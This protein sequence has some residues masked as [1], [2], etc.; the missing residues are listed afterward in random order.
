MVTGTR[1][2]ASWAQQRGGEGEFEIRNGS[3]LELSE[4]WNGPFDGF[5]FDPPYGRNAWKSTDGFDLLEG[6]L[7]AC[8]SV[9]TENANLVTLLPWPPSAIFE[10]IESGTSFGKSWAEISDA[11]ATAG[12]EIMSTTPI[13]VH[14]S[15]ARMLIHARKIEK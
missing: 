5:A 13:R 3:A 15:L 6:A 14:R 9:A 4:I 7:S 1:E 10:S 11:F 8:N 12:W 2:N